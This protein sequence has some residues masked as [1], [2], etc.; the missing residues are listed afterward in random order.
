MSQTRTIRYCDFFNK[1]SIFG[2]F[3]HWVV[4]IKNLTFSPSVQG[5]SLHSAFLRVHFCPG[6]GE[7]CAL[8]LMKYYSGRRE[9]NNNK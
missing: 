1:I 5:L 2:P 8:E 4:I 7:V 9:H 3:L 6:G